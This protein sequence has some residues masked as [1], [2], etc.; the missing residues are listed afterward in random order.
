MSTFIY[1]KSFAHAYERLLYTCFHGPDFVSRPRDMEVKELISPAIRVT[2][3]LDRFYKSEARST[4]MKYCAGEYL[5]YFGQRNDP[6]FISK[7]SAFWNSLKNSA[8]TDMLEENTVN[9][10]YGMLAMSER[11]ADATWAGMPIT[12]WN[13]ALRSIIRDNDSRQAIVHINRPKHQV[14]WVKDFPCTMSFQFFLRSGKLYMVANMRSNDL[15]KGLTFDFPMFTF[16]QEQFL[17]DLVSRSSFEGRPVHAELGSITVIAGSS[18]IYERD[19]DLVSSMLKT[20]I[21]SMD[22]VA[23]ISAPVVQVDKHEGSSPIWATE[24]N[25]QFSA[26]MK[27]AE[28]CDRS[29]FD[30]LTLDP[31]HAAFAAALEPR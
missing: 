30:G 9:S 18:H 7:Y 21:S 3:P 19:Y 27:F 2:N 17:S 8:S 31:V 11:W 20:G 5:W 25:P 22:P 26:L 16:F 29:A 13:W 1:G 12:Q 15:I 4:P 23:P 10:S 28:T 24:F 6:E 14:D